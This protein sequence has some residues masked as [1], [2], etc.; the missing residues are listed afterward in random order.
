MIDAGR[1]VDRRRPARAT[2]RVGYLVAV[3][4]DLVL[5]WL[6]NGWPGWQAVP[7]LTD[8]FTRVLGVLNLSLT[9]GAVANATYLVVDPAWYRALTQAGLD[10]ISVVV[11]AR[12]LAVFPFDVQTSAHDWTPWLRALLV[13]GLVGTAIAVVVELV[14]FVRA[15]LGLG[16]QVG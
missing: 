4:V 3:A 15:V 9:A 16:E 11:L 8:D 10:G 12:L 6:V 7:F 14:R 2:R 13:L 5:L 1:T